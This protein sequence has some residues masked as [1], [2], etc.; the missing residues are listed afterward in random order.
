MRH[1]VDLD[2]LSSTVNEPSSRVFD[3][4]PP[5]QQLKGRDGAADDGPRGGVI[6]MIQRETT[7]CWGGIKTVGRGW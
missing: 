5:S 6:Y 7:G 1:F 3:E 2:R 4:K